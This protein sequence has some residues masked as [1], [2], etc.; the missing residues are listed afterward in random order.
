MPGNHPAKSSQ[1][2]SCKIYEK[3]VSGGKIEYYLYG[4]MLLCPASEIGRRVQL[5]GKTEPGPRSPKS[6][7]HQYKTA[8]ALSLTLF[9]PAAL[10]TPAA[11]YFGIQN[12]RSGSAFHIA[13]PGSSSVPQ[14][15]SQEAPSKERQV[16]RELV[17]PSCLTPLVLPRP[18]HMRSEQQEILWNPSITCHV[19]PGA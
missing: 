4:D 16:V 12:R 17:N 11:I 13:C 15:K 14:T 19:L 10:R 2:A 3:C 8:S 1:N 9:S 5:L 6:S 7:S 18:L